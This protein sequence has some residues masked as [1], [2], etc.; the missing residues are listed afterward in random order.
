[1][2][3]DLSSLKTLETLAKSATADHREVTKR[4]EGLMEARIDAIVKEQGVSRRDAHARASKTD[5]VYKQAY[6]LHCESHV[7][8]VQRQAM[9]DGLGA[10][11]R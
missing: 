4:L 1:M 7:R 9:V 6:A 3:T 8:A 5:G 10:Y 11:I 2:N